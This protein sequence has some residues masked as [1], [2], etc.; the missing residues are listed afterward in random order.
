VSKKHPVARRDI[1]IISIVAFISAGSI[2][3]M[4][5]I[6]W[7]DWAWVWHY[8]SSDGLDGFFEPFRWLRHVSVG[9]LLFLN[10]QFFDISLER[11]TIFWGILRFAVILANALLIY[12]IAKRILKNYTPIG[13]MAS[14][15][16]LVSPAV[17]NYCLVTFNYYVLLMLY[18]SSVL[19][20]V[21]AIGPSGIRWP[22][23]LSSLLLSAVAMASLESF[24]V[25]DL[26]RPVLFYYV[27]KTSRGIGRR[28]AVLSAIK[29]WALFA[30]IGA[31][32]AIDTLLRPQSGAYAGVYA[33]GAPSVEFA[34]TVLDRFAESL[35]Y[36]FFNVYKHS[37]KYAIVKEPDVI[38]MSL[39]LISA[40][41]VCYV[42]YRRQA[43]H[44]D[45]GMARAGIVFGIFTVIVGLIPYVLTRGAV[46]YGLESRH[47]LLASLGAA[48]LIPSA[49]C[50]VAYKGSWGMKAAVALV[51]SFVFLGSLGMNHAIGEYKRNWEHQRQIMWQLIWRAPDIKP[52][53]FMLIAMPWPEAPGG[54]S[55]VLPAALNLAYAKSINEGELNNK[56]AVELLNALR[57]DEMN[58]RSLA[59][60]DEH[61][62]MIFKGPIKI[63]P[64]N[65]ISASYKD[66]YLYLDDE[67]DTPVRG[68]KDDMQF[69]LSRASHDRIVYNPP[70]DIKFPLR[71]VLG[72]EPE[73]DWSYYY[74]KANAYFGV[75]NY[76]AIVKLYE[77]AGAKGYDLKSIRP[78]N[79][80]PFIAASYA[81]M[82]F[83][84][85]ADLL[86]AWAV[87]GC[88]NRNRAMAA[89]KT[90]S[91]G[92][93]VY[94]IM[95]NDID[96]ILPGN[97]TR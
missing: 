83:Q 8:F 21:Y 48:V 52:N 59:D 62:M 23:Y 19:L 17:N 96:Y 33:A 91:G 53:T 75:G 72:P 5:G 2:I 86:K 35:K 9:L 54:G 81:T 68:T 70:S 41:I 27:F 49:I 42:F 56:Y 66:G 36:I 95:K 16:F 45:S 46:D 29:H 97:I 6:W 80:L 40:C 18:L 94:K 39:S 76:K 93:D 90:V 20:S 58:F 57:A 88:G 4:S 22:Y 11:A 37:F 25:F 10:F 85:G 67:I 44:P 69:M 24:I 55:Y 47:G 12:A 89:I 38:A 77:E 32:V 78:E 31:S 7:D 15:F 92:A 74:Q 82:D 43:K 71:G 79:L 60:K 63:Y 65:L 3:G 87:K 51:G 26:I 30:A 61:E 28:A 14:L 84:R 13:L 34:K 73:H 50:I 64:K 1:F